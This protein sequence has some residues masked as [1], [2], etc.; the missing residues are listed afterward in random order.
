MLRQA[1]PG[2]SNL[3]DFIKVIH[4]GLRVA[5]SAL[6]RAASSCA[7]THECVLQLTTESRP[8]HHLATQS[9]TTVTPRSSVPGLSSLTL[10]RLSIPKPAVTAKPR[11]TE[12]SRTLRRAST[13]QHAISGGHGCCCRYRT[14]KLLSDAAKL[15]ARD[16]QKFSTHGQRRR[17]E[18]ANATVTSTC[19]KPYELTPIADA[20]EPSLVS[21]PRHGPCSQQSTRSESASSY[22]EPHASQE[23]RPTANA[24]SSTT[25]PLPGN[26]SHRCRRGTSIRQREAIPP[27]SQ[28][29]RSAAE[30][31]G[32][33]TA[34]IQGE[35]TIST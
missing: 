21:E 5:S 8:E 30:V 32:S 31:G 16:D 19:T 27:H 12:L 11:W 13:T 9:T 4:D 7:S 14:V 22:D 6:V 23:L 10:P 1:P 29:P 17:Q 15:N 34:H 26:R 24:T 33:V 18:R 3:T 2:S 20:A 25:P 35:K 28:A